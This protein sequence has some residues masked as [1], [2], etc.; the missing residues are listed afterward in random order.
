MVNLAQNTANLLESDSLNLNCDG[1]TS[2]P[3]F[4]E[5]FLDLGNLMVI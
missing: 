1:T 2:V 4:R 3:R 5:I